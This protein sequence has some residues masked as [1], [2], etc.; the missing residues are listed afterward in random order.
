MPFVQAGSGKHPIRRW[1]SWYDKRLVTAAGEAILTELDTWAISQLRAHKL[2]WSGWGPMQALPRSDETVPGTGWSVR[3]VSGIDPRRL[4]LFFLSLLWR[5]AAT[6]RPEF[7]EVDMPAKDIEK[8]RSMLVAGDPEPLSFYPTTLTQLS[9]LGITHNLTPL[10]ET[11]TIPGLGGE[12][13]QT[14]PYFRFYFD[15]LIAHM[16]RQASD[17]GV[18]GG[19]GPLVVGAGGELVLSTIPFETSFERENLRVVMSES[20]GTWP[21]IDL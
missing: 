10:A 8:L 20:K 21:G 13:D 7:S 3:K 5:A 14:V 16:H 17:G 1:S 19:L 15:G 9:T 6:D 18:S 12:A 11:K 4:R 2:V